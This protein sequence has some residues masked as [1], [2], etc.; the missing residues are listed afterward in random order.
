MSVHARLSPSGSKRWMACAGSIALEAAFPDAPNDFSDRGTACHN[1]AAECLVTEGLHPSDWLGEMIRVNDPEEADRHVFFDQTLCDYTT[2]YVDEIL[3]LT[4]GKEL[5]V[6]TRVEFSE[7]IDVPD[8]FGT[9]D[10]H[11]LEQ[12]EVTFEFAGQTGVQDASEI[13]ICDLKTGFKYVD[14]STPQLKCYALGVLS[15]FELSHDIRQVRL[16]IYQPTHGGMREEVISIDELMEFAK[17]LK[18]AAL[19]VEQA[20]ALHA[21]IM[22]APDCDCDSLCEA[23]PGPDPDVN[24]CKLVRRDAL[25]EWQK[26]YLHPNPNEEDCAF[27]RAYATCP[28]MQAKIQQVVGEGFDT[29][30]EDG[31]AVTPTNLGDDKLAVAMQAAGMLE[32][33]IK[34]VRAEVERR[35]LLGQPVKWGDGDDEGFGLELGRQGNRRWEDPKTIEKLLRETY[36]LKIEDVYNMSL[37]SP[38]DAEKLAKVTKPT[39]KTPNPPKPK[40]TPARWQSLQKQIRRSDAVPS[41]KPLSKITEPYSPVQPDADAFEVV[42]EGPAV[43]N[44]APLW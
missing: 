21:A 24:E 5:F 26:I 8:Q 31:G 29:V 9:I 4:K 42:L 35:L 2:G 11:W 41:V 7:Y 40:I 33:W 6:E 37:I 17:T 36:R 14:T 44:E 43:D 3:A 12:I 22:R 34:A 1:V 30:I 27:C 38:T 15:R 25:I 28:A 20:T 32:D 39:K 16:M 13:V 19:R 23:A 18:A 10:A